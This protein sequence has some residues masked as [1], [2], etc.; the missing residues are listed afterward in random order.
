MPN[1]FLPISLLSNSD[2]PN[3][4][5]PNRLLSNSD[6]SNSILQNCVLPNSLL[7]DSGDLPNR[8]YNY[9]LPKTILAHFLFLRFNTAMELNLLTILTFILL[10]TNG[11]RHLLH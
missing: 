2:L 4:V 6:I 7:S 9:L 10:Y 1:R 3:S 11:F 5:L 8:A